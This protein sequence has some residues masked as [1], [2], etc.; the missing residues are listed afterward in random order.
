MH[1]MAIAGNIV[2]VVK[3]AIPTSM[4]SQRVSGVVVEVGRLST[5]V[6]ESLK[7]CFGVVSKETVCEGAELEVIEIPLVLKCRVCSHRW[8]ADE[9]AFI[10][11]DCGGI[12]LAVESGRELSVKTVRLEE[13]PEVS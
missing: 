9:P 11:P 8:E 12:D 6:P 13:L 2:G 10:C 1:E 7:F 4:E 5:V 3:D